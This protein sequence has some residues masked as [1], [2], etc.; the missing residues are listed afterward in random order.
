MDALA[1]RGTTLKMGDGGDPEVFT[2]IAKVVNISGPSLALD[3]EDATDHDS[4]GGWEEV[5]ATILRTG[6]VTFTIHYLPA[7]ATH[8]DATGLVRKM[9]DRTKTNFQLVFPDAAPTQWDFAAFVTGFEPQA[10]HEG[11]LVADVTMKPS[12]QPTLA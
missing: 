4:P 10:P 2:P 12:G 7:S 6:E 3:T 1:A 5:V 8:G 9:R 11:K